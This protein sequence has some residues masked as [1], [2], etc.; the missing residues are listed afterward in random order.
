MLYLLCYRWNP[1]GWYLHCT[2][3]GHKGRYAWKFCEF[4]ISI[5][6]M[7]NIK[8]KPTSRSVS[9]H[10]I[11]SHDDDNA[12]HACHLLWAKAKKQSV[13]CSSAVGTCATAPLPAD[14]AHAGLALKS[15]T[16][17]GIE[18]SD[19]CAAPEARCAQART[20][21][22]E[23]TSTLATTN[24][25]HLAACRPSSPK[26]SSCPYNKDSSIDF[27]YKVVEGLVPALPPEHFLTQQRP[28]R[29]ICSCPNSSASIKKKNYRLIT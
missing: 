24:P 2:D 17:T 25:P 11:C 22:V 20:H 26:C 3:L 28:C 19:L 14:T 1:E 13:S 21:P 5:W 7:P 9:C 6:V 10:H 29:L 27:F 15:I 18:F 8:L 23:P 16:T 12:V 4:I